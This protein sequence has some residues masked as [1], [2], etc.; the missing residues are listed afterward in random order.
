MDYLLKIMI[1]FSI[2]FFPYLLIQSLL[3]F[4]DYVS[5]ERNILKLEEEYERN[6]DSRKEFINH[7][8]WSIHSGEKEDLD[9]LK[10]AIVKSTKKIFKIIDEYE[11]KFANKIK[12]D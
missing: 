5:K 6:V 9:Y 3:A 8:H 4:K 7:Y 10:R 1:I 11:S 2:A 12:K